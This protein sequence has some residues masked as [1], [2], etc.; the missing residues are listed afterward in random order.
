MYLKSIFSIFLSVLCGGLLFAQDLPQPS[1]AA[2]VE[3]R[4]GLTDVVVKYARP[5]IKGR[6]VWGD[7]VPYNQVWRTGAN[8]STLVSFSEEVS[9]KG[10]KLPKGEYALFCIPTENEWTVIFNKNLTLWG[11]DGYKQEEDVLRVSLKPTFNNPHVESFLIAFD[12]L[13]LSGGE[14]VLMW[15]KMRLSIP[16]ETDVTKKAMGNIEK[17]I[18]ELDRGFRVYNTS[19]SYLLDANQEPAKALEYAQKSVAMRE[20]FWNVYTLSRAHAANKQ[21]KE[22]LAAAEKSLKLAK[23]AKY[24]PY[25]KM[26]EENMA[27]WKKLAK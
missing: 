14:L 21:Y 27:Q 2:K 13:Q 4:I 15:E 17:A 25:V 9:I 7:L 16:I 18:A 11:A 19:A 12:Q 24:E 23:D 20:V 1:P 3:Q 26:N 8:A 10:Q 5:S 22:A 6:K